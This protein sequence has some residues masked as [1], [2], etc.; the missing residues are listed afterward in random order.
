MPISIIYNSLQQILVA[1]WTTVAQAAGPQSDY[2]Y[3]EEISSVSSPPWRGDLPLH[4]F[5]IIFLFLSLPP[6]PPSFSLGR[7]GV[8]GMKVNKL[9]LFK[10]SRLYEL[11]P[12]KLIT[13]S[14]FLIATTA[15]G[16]NIEASGQEIHNIQHQQYKTPQPKKSHTHT[17][18]QKKQ[19]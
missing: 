16:T 8:H 9:F 18:T 1:Q 3:W 7:T 5:H 10:L 14:G 6:P 4:F 15:A 2:S 12:V 13:T 17:H 19:K 11:L